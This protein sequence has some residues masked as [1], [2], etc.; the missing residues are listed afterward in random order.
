MLMLRT[1]RNPR[2]WRNAIL[3]IALCLIAFALGYLSLAVVQ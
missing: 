3:L 1:P 2:L